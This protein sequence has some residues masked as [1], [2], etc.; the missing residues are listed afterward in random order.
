[1]YAL[2]RREE[3]LLEIPPTASPVGA[4][5]PFPIR[6]NRNDHLMNLFKLSRTLKFKASLLQK[7]VSLLPEIPNQLQVVQDWLIGLLLHP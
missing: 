6:D 1:L 5:L 7:I 3:F 4:N 2:T